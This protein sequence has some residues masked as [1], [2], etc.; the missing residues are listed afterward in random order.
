MGIKQKLFSNMFIRNMLASFWNRSGYSHEPGSFEPYFQYKIGSY[1]LD[2]YLYFPKEPFALRYKNEIF[3]KLLEYR[4]YDIIR[5]LEFHYTAY[6]NPGGFLR[7]LNYEIFERLKKQRKNS[8]LLTAQA[9]VTEKTEEF[10]KGQEAQI[11]QEVKDVVQEIVTS[12]PTPS[13][14]EVEQYVSALV[15][16]FTGHM[17]RITSETE[18]GIKDLTGSFV[19]GKVELN[20]RNHEEKLM[21]VFII[22]QDLKAPS[23]V[24]KAEQ[25]FK[26][27][28]DSDLA[29]Y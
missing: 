17:D 14:I 29:A 28:T 11:R 4:G 24:S 7:F 2:L 10:L 8:G 21:Q 18:Q 3:N 25:V 9:W 26:R 13:A 22:L 6:P 16:K 1:Q 12:Q 20:N 19:K 15:E 5:Y 27:F 23:Q